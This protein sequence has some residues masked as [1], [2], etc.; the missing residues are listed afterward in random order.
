MQVNRFDAIT[1]HSR[2][3]SISI[4]KKSEREGEIFELELD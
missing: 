4:L 1:I 2:E 3:S